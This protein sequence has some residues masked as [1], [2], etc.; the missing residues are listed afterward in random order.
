MGISPFGGFGDVMFTVVPII[1]AVGFFFVFGTIIV[2]A[3]QGTKQW[4]TNNDSPV[5]TVDA[6]VVARRADVH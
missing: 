4:K 6:T 3:I 1:I 5:L 2:R